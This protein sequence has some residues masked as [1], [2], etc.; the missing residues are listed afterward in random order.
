MYEFHSEL[1][2]HPA[3]TDCPLLV[4]IGKSTLPSLAILRGPCREPGTPRWFGEG[5]FAGMGS[6]RPLVVLKKPH[7]SCLPLKP[8]HRLQGIF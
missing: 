6:F 1:V 7:I 2:P 3:D 8:R 5:F 4:L